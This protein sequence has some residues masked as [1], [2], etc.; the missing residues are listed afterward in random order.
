[1]PPV[2]LHCENRRWRA[3]P[4]CL[5][6]LRR[7]D[8]LAAPICGRCGLPGCPD[9]HADWP[10]AFSSTRFLF[11]VTPE[12]STVV[13][14]F[15]YRH[16]RR[17]VGFLGAYL[18]FRPDLV[19]HIRGFDALVPIPLHAV[20]LRE[21]GYNQAGLIA[22]VLGR[23][24]GVPVWA[25]ALRRIRAT[26]TQTALGREERQRNL[27]GAFACAKPEKL[28]GRRLLLIDDV[29]TTGATTAACAETLRRANCGEVGVFA[30][31]LVKTETAADDFV[32]EMEAVAGYL[33]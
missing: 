10:H 19:E 1:M 6:C 24:A 5:T 32:K 17:H 11:R 23:A 2:C 16:M 14:G 13:H 27:G 28:Q 29:F 18:R 25:D 20:R 33:V 21:R 7:L 4:L 15:K 9:Q 31:G 8:R 22:D 12:L 26:G 3:A 30:L